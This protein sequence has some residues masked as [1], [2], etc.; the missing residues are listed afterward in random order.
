MNSKK[1]LMTIGIIIISVVLLFALT[2]CGK[3]DNTE[4]PSNSNNSGSGDVFEYGQEYINNNLK[5]YWLEYTITSY[6]NGNT[7]SATMEVRKTEQGYYWAVDGSSMLFI[8]NGDKYDMYMESDG[9]YVNSGVQQEKDAVEGMM[10]GITTY[11]MGYA[12]YSSEL[13]KSGTEVIAG[14]TCDKYIMEYSYPGYNYKYNYIYYID[15]ET[16]VGLKFTMD[17]V[18][19]SEKVGYEFEATKFETSG[20]T[21]PSY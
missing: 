10:S 13:K 12:G 9:S 21:L 17:I 4:K 14:R 2:G 11:M 3:N 7:D 15:K 20:V 16:G 8:K 1:I 19:G 5:D 18:S 6:E